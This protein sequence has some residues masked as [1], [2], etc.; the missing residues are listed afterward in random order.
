MTNKFRV[1]W[2]NGTDEVLDHAGTR[3]ELI[4]EMWGDSWGAFEMRG[5]E[6]TMLT[7]VSQEELD[8]AEALAKAE[9]EKAEAEALAKAEAEAGSGDADA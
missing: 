5:G 9:A 1:V 7:L 4:A 2:P 6:L 8:E 3:D